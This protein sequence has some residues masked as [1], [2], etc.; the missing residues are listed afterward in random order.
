MLDLNYRKRKQFVNL[1]RCN[2]NAKAVFVL[3]C[4]IILIHTK[5]LKCKPSITRDNQR[6]VNPQATVHQREDNP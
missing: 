1:R 6:D 5:H 4:N 3:G 2:L